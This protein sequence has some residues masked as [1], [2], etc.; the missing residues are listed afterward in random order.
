MFV[1]FTCS[2]VACV[3]LESYCKQLILHLS[4]SLL[5][6]CFLVPLY[7]HEVYM[8]ERNVTARFRFSQEAVGSVSRAY[9]NIACIVSYFPFG[10]L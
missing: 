5:S 1:S 7:L 8:A 6:P 2:G 3:Q 9:D 4:L 10:I